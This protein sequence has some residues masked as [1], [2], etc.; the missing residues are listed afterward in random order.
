MKITLS[1]FTVVVDTREQARYDFSAIP[2]RV[3]DGGG[4]VI[5]PTVRYT[6]KSGDYSIATWEDR[7]AVE[8][9]SLEDLYGSLGRNRNRFKRE[10]V[11]LNELE[12]AAVVVEADWAAL[13]D[14]DKHRA[15][16]H[17]TLN[18]ASVIGTIMAWDQRY[19]NVSWYFPGTRSEAEIATYQILERFWKETKK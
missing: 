15:V 2:A 4:V 13:K 16:W 9:K 17:S 5:V 11:R 3:A 18:S 12:F 14:P 10:I 7:V 8:R 6:L 1:P 19:R